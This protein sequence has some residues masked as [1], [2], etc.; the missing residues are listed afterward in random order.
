[1]H[2]KVRSTG[3][4]LLVVWSLVISWLLPFHFFKSALGGLGVVLCVFVVGKRHACQ[5]EWPFII[6]VIITP[7]VPHSH[8]T[9]SRVDARVSPD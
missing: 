8:F 1:M 5:S 2:G 9:V 7:H 4:E 6:I 3:A